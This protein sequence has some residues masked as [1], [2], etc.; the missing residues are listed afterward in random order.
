MEH[1]LYRL[2][3]KLLKSRGELSKI[4]QEKN[5]TPHEFS[6][7]LENSSNQLKNKLA[8][9]ID[10]HFDEFGIYKN[11]W[12]E[13]KKKI[14]ADKQRQL[15]DEKNQEY[16][17]FLK[18]NIN[19]V[20]TRMV[21]QSAT[22]PTSANLLKQKDKNEDIEKILNSELV[23]LFHEHPGL[24]ETLDQEVNQKHKSYYNSTGIFPNH[25][26]LHQVL[27]YKMTPN[28]IGTAKNNLDYQKKL[29]LENEGLSN[30]ALR[31][32]NQ[33]QKQKSVKKS[34]KNGKL[35]VSIPNVEYPKFFENDRDK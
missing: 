10:G 35:P 7:K 20:K 26:D 4:E 25:N 30:A 32:T 16:M 17:Q 2:K 6:K 15:E 19:S 9:L 34:E 33:Q 13:Y 22:R 28:L 23:N 31:F 5:Y 18:K 24:Q 11:K 27:L 14:M 3:V 12:E 21:S 8:S 1:Q 29:N